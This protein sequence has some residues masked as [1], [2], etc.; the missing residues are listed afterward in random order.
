[1]PP[2]RDG[3]SALRPLRSCTLKPVILVRVRSA[4]GPC[5]PGAR[6]HS[7][8]VVPFDGVWCCRCG[9]LTPSGRLFAMLLVR[10]RRAAPRARLRLASTPPFPADPAC[11]QATFTT[12][13]VRTRVRRRL[14]TCYYTYRS[15]P[16]GCHRQFHRHCS[17]RLLTDFPA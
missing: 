6:A 3:S 10:L 5:R 14:S 15:S 12:F 7:Q 4:R 8:Q 9:W 16:P 2:R 1:V 11:D 13:V 17:T